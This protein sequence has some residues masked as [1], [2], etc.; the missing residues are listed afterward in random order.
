MSLIFFISVLGGYWCSTIV[1]Y[2]SWRIDLLAPSVQFRHSVMSDS[3]QPHGLQQARLPCPSPTPGAC[4]NSCPSS[5]WCHPTISCSVVPLSP[6]SQSFPASQSFPVNQF[7]T[8]GGQSIGFQI[9]LSPSNEYSG[10]I[11]FRMNWFDLLAVQG[12]LK[13]LLQHHS[14]KASILQHLAFFIVQLSHPNPFGSLGRFIPR[15]FIFTLMVNEIIS[16]V[17]LSGILSVYRNATDFYI[18]ILYPATLPNSLMNSGGIFRNF[19]V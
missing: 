2:A 19:Y 10:L 12:P 9:Q 18:L 5:R 7:F 15:Y 1:F 13:S 4:S 8:S 11:S 14:S 16:L 3:L 6:W 17:Y